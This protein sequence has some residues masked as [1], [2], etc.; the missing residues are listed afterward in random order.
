MLVALCL[1]QFL[2][3]G[4]R[5]L[6]LMTSFECCCP[7]LRLKDRVCWWLKRSKPLPTS[8]SCRQHISSPTS[9][10][11]IDLTL[12]VG[13][14]FQD[15]KLSSTFSSRIYSVGIESV[16]MESV[17][18]LFNTLYLALRGLLN[19]KVPDILFNRLEIP[20]NQFLCGLYYKIETILIFETFIKL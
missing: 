7:T 18:G 10:P 20:K 15:R 12:K 5:I 3:V 9:V 16:S 19:P 17:E 11:S 14:L 8:Q 6:I 2:G 4:D 13:Y 1:W